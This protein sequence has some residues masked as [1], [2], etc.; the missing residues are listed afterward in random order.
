METCR[1]KSCKKFDNANKTKTYHDSH[2]VN[3]QK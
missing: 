2:S 3:V 1:G